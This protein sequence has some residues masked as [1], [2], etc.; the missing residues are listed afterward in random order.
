MTFLNN[1]SSNAT[2]T[3]LPD[4]QYLTSPSGEQPGLATTTTSS[5]INHIPTCPIPKSVDCNQYG[6]NITNN[7]NHQHQHQHHHTNTTHVST[8]EV[9]DS[10]LS[11]RSCLQM[12]RQPSLNSFPT[13]QPTTNIGRIMTGKIDP[14]ETKKSDASCFFQSVLI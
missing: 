11:P 2:T 5:S 4:F 12:K 14:S 13:Q 6:S 3:V 8:S 7:N 10:Q 9:K 1:N